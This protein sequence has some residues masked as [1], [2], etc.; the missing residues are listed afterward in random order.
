ME[1]TLYLT[2]NDGVGEITEVGPGVRGSKGGRVA[3]GKGQSGTWCNAQML[4]GE[5]AIKVGGGS[6]ISAVNASTL[7]ASRLTKT[8][9]AERVD[10]RCRL[11]L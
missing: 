6:G 10:S 2:G 1:K 9:S 3:L 8:R 4:E 5:D 7:T 11:I